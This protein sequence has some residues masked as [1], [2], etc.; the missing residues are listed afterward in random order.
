MQS[1]ARRQSRLN[2][3]CALISL[4]IMVGAHS[5]SAVAAIL[6]A[7]QMYLDPWDVPLDTYDRDY[8]YPLTT[9]NSIQWGGNIVDVDVLPMLKP[10][11]PGDPAG[12]PTGYG[13]SS[14]NYYYTPVADYLVDLSAGVAIA[15][16]NKEGIYHA[17]LTRNDGTSEIRAVLVNAGTLGGDQRTTASVPI[18]GPIADLVIVSDPTGGDATLDIAS[19]NAIDDNGAGKVNRAS[20]VSEAIEKIRDAFVRNGRKKL[21]LEVVAHGRP[22]YFEL[23]DTRIGQGG[24]ISIKDFQDLID[25]YVKEISVFACS[26]AADGMVGLQ[27][28]ADSIGYAWGYDKPVSVYRNWFGLSRGWD[29]SLQGKA[30]SAVPEPSSILLVIVGWAA[31]AFTRNVRERMRG[32]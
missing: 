2:G 18:G 5:P 16:F 3:T 24:T 7:D 14:S 15:T 9:G 25:E 4:L 1:T 28:L 32:L 31:L 19:A 17:R 11:S 21:H 8:L 6:T 26:F 23:G 10:Y 29:L 20:S 13:F 22:G 30:L 27:T 12:Y